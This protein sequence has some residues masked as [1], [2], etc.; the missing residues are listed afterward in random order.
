MNSFPN[1]PT[2][3]RTNSNGKTFPPILKMFIDQINSTQWKWVVCIIC[4]VSKRYFTYFDIRFGIFLVGGHF[5]VENYGIYNRVCCNQIS[6]NQ[7]CYL[8]ILSVVSRRHKLYRLH[9]LKSFTWLTA[10]NIE[11]FQTKFMFR[12]H[13][14]LNEIVS[15]FHLIPIFI[16][17]PFVSLCLC[18]FIRIWA[19]NCFVCVCVRVLVKILLIFPFDCVSTNKCLM[20]IWM[21]VRVFVYRLAEFRKSHFYGAGKPGAR[22]LIISFSL[23]RS[24]FIHRRFAFFSLSLCSLLLSYFNTRSLHQV[25]RAEQINLKE[26]ENSNKE[27]PNKN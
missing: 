2:L 19:F 1:E 26:A 18:V 10:S 13:L 8:Y 9:Q 22:F 24:Q 17:V 16:L 11:C 21:Y 7:K 12:L 25:Y 6:M 14:L 3:K 4:T 23:F 5:N 20:Y 15:F 27:I